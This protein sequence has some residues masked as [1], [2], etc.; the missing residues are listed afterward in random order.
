L[1]AQRTNNGTYER[2]DLAVIPEF[3]ATVGWQLNPCWRVTFGY[4][5][6][7]WSNVVRAGQQI[8][9]DINVNLLPP[10]AIPFEGNLRPRFQF[11]DTDFFVQGISVGL[12]GRW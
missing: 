8:D 10:E 9:R 12:D 5:F 7:Y 3:G 1:L 4:T 11:N 2:D 6:I